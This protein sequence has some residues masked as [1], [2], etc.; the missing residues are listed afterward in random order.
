MLLTQTYAHN[1]LLVHMFTLLTVHQYLLE[2]IY[3]RFV[4]PFY[5]CH[6]YLKHSLCTL[7]GTLAIAT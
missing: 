3:P 2:R 7:Q 1:E 6:D 5:G 4:F